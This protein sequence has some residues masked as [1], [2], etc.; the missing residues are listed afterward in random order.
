MIDARA[1]HAPVVPAQETAEALRDSEW[2]FQAL[3]EQAAVGMCFV[4]LGG[5]F[6]RTNRRL[7]EIVGFTA[8]ELTRRTCVELTHPDDRPREKILTGRMV[9]GELRSSAWEKRFVRN[10][11]SPVWCNLTLTLLDDESGRPS[12]FVGVIED[13][14]E[15]K[16]SAQRLQQSESL[17]RIAGQTVHLGWWACD[18]ADGAMS[19]S[20]EVCA[21]HDVA[22]GSAPNLAAMFAFYRA[23]SRERIVAAMERCLRASEAFDLELE[24]TSARGRHRW[25]RAIGQSDASL[26]RLV[27]AMQDI[28]ER[29]E[30][31]L[32]MV[33][34]NR[35]LQMM[36][37]C[38]EVLIRATDERQLLADIC[39]LVVDV[40]GYIMAWVGYAR[41]DERRSVDV[42]AV[43]GKADG[44]F[45]VSR[46]SWAGDDAEGRG[47]VGR[48]I[49]NGTVT[50]IG[51]LATDPDFAPWR[52]SA[53]ER[54]YRSIVSLPLRDGATTFG[55]LCLYGG[56]VAN[57]PQAELDLLQ[58]LADDLA[59]GIGHL[60]TQVEQQRIQEA[61]LK[62][63][64]AVSVRASTE[65]FER[66]VSNMADAVGAD[67]AFI[68]RYDPRTPQEA[69]T[70]V[71]F[72]DG[73]THANLGFAIAG[74]PCGELRSDAPWIV[75][76][77][78]AERYPD[79]KLTALTRAT[80]FVGW[81]LDDSA[82][83][84]LAMMFVLFREPLVE[85]EFTTSTLKIFLSR[86]AAELERQSSDARIAD[87][88]SWLDKARDA[89]VV[90]A[91]D[92]RISF[93]N[94]SAERLYGWTSGEALGAKFTDVLLQDSPQVRQASADVLEFG[95]WNGEIEHCRKDGSLVRVESRW[96]IMRDVD[97]R[98]RSI[99]SIDTD[100]TQ[101]KAAERE[102][103]HLAFYDTLTELPNRLLLLQR[104]KIA[105]ATYGRV[106]ALLFI[107]LDNFK[108][109]NDT[110]GHD[111]G[112]LLL[113]HVAVRLQGCVRTEDTVARLG[114][115]EFVVMLEDLGETREEATANGK[116]IADTILAAFNAPYQLGAYEHN[117]TPSIGITVFT[118]G[119]QTD[120]LLKQADLAMYQAKA[121]GRNAIRVFDPHIQATVNARRALEDDIRS[122]LRARDFTL[123]Y[124][125]QVDETGTVVGAEALVRWQHDGRGD[126][127]PVAFI[128]VAE[129]SGLIV[130][131]GRWIFSTAC[132]QLAAWS[133]DPRL[134]KLK[135]SVNV[136]AREFR[137]PEFV[138]QVLDILARSAADPR[139]LVLELT[140][141]VVVD[142]IEVVIEKMTALRD[143]GVGFSLDDFGTGYSSLSYLKR[144]PLDQLKIDQSFVRDVLVD[145]NDAVIARTIIALGRSLTLD[146]IAEGVETHAQREFLTSNGCR[147]FQGYLFSRPIPAPAFGAFVGAWRP[148]TK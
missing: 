92:D 110:L 96:T 28:T 31:E 44:Y 141:S 139:L 3:F 70:I 102:I 79:C 26:G 56:D 132:A 136:S 19:W 117:S 99:L 143:I 11:G 75:P 30:A 114:G 80:A 29:K 126:V 95:F 68:A 42:V 47:S 71:A 64:A 69:Q 32:E 131:L 25:I 77:G 104:L 37:G 82:G 134:A 14:T 93:W 65:F 9:A 84:P 125:P 2:R 101:R 89:I 61:V 105:L 133:R 81:R 140:E 88:A 12:Q 94:K 124:Q 83:E 111:Q 100:I 108:T 13:I 91:V 76:A 103:E 46:C 146:V 148:Y 39:K 54:G 16:L 21:I 55:V 15:R 51:D 119:D 73:E 58:E 98:S 40:G 137:H 67:A 49:R 35:A 53:L 121:A 87:Q 10:D 1:T 34:I 48:T 90:R 128:P 120:D 142:D 27:G 116:L 127:P 18:V 52:I 50:V 20:D 107:D 63:S 122:A 113:Q 118:Y 138:H 5:E 147:S 22:I 78:L 129:D 86:A 45:S 112:D 66:L 60:R 123:V 74:T 62:I 72:V 7:S 85:S 23:G 59:F 33:R 24:I 43:A 57:P 41:H 97:G 115:D 17:L 38:N 145:A 144:L 6:L 130:P 106:G 36:S 8:E 109:L 4:S 135:L